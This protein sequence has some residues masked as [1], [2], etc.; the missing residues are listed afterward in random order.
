MNLFFATFCLLGQAPAPEA[1]E[2]VAPA[3]APAPDRWPLMQALQG[4]YPGWLL[5]GA[6]LKLYGW[7]DST[8]T[9]S[10]DRH[11]QLPM[12]FNYRANE[13]QLQ[14]AWVRFERP[15]DQ[16]ANAPTF[17]FRSDTFF[18]IDYRFTIARGLFDS[19]LTAD[20]GRSNLYGFDPV[21]F[22]AEAYFPHI[23]RGL[24]VKVGRFFAQFGA[25]S[26]DT[27]QT[28]FV[29]RSYSFIYD[30]FTHTGLLTTLKLTDTWS[31]QNGVATGCDV[32]IDPACT[33]TYL[34]SVKWA[35][36]NGRSTA[37]FAVILCSGR[38][39]QN[40]NFHNPQ[41]FDLV[42]THK[43]GPRLTYTLDALY[44]FTHNVP[45][46]GFANW[47]ATDHYLSWTLAPR[48]TANARLEFFDDEQ[49]QRTGFEGLYTA[50]TAGLAVTPNRYVLFRPEVRYDYNG[51]SRPFEG[52][53]GVFTAALDMVVR[54]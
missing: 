42:F 35:P 36:P 1:E 10:S 34:G 26:I 40:Q 49:G 32:F 14:Q 5:D 53:H 27:T 30:P 2:A 28:V 12:G 6:K 13:G 23:C 25:E 18:G 51:T 9:A 7:I 33:P 44:G 41:I 19:Q 37:L 29:S 24:D 47:W 43:L 11:E 16:T 39:D 45:N 22:Y 52:K 3:A 21:Q 48:V 8:F 38:F 20:H 4:T 17:G 50:L 54:W 46:T 31:V 15:V